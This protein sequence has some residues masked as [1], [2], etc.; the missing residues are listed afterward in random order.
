MSIVSK[1]G[2]YCLQW[3]FLDKNKDLSADTLGYY[4]SIEQCT[5]LA[6]EFGIANK[7][8]SRRKDGEELILFIIDYD[9]A[10]IY[11]YCPWT[12]EFKLQ[13]L[14]EILNDGKEITL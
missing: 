3:E 4:N 10:E 11:D 12:Q 6:R 7:I 5:P 8:L 14:H 1:E 9:T 2:R 13:P